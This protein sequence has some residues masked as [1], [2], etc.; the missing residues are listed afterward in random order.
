MKD[1]VICYQGKPRGDS[2]KLD[3]HGFVDIDWA[4]DLDRQRLTI[5]Y[6]FKMFGGEISWMS[7][8]HVVI[9]LSTKK[10]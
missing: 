8:R 5:G 4:G 7:K 2:G 3:V 9:A 1:Y 6:V 10:I